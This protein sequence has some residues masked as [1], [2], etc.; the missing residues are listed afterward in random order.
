MNANLIHK[1]FRDPRFGAYFSDDALEINE[2]PSFLPT[3][4]EAVGA[5]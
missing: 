1:W 4:I 3:E 2:E 5:I